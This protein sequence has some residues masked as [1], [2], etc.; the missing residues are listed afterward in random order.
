MID[1]PKAVRCTAHNWWVWRWGDT[2]NQH[3]PFV[4]STSITHSWR[5]RC[6]VDVRRVNGAATVETAWGLLKETEAELPFDPVIPLL[7][8]YPKETNSESLEPCAPCP[9]PFIADWPQTRLQ[10]PLMGGGQIKKTGHVRTAEG[11]S[12]LQGRTPFHL[13]LMAEK[14]QYCRWL[15]SQL[16]DPEAIGLWYLFAALMFRLRKWISFYR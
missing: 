6:C 15:A 9:S 1:I 3:P 10:C 2:W 7:D 4:I 8:I 12:A 13:F 5:R 14:Q 16:L 11:H